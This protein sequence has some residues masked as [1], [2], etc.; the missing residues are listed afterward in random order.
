MPGCEWVCLLQLMR[1]GTR[2]CILDSEVVA[3][4]REKGQI[5]PFQVLSTRKR[6]GAELANIKVNVCLF[7]FDLLY[8]NGK[9]HLPCDCH[10]TCFMALFFYK[11]SRD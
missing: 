4:D 7:L 9:V 8:L 3:W 10:V 2:S 5:L 1:E 6:K 11:V